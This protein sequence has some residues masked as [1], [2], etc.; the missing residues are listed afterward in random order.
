MAYIIPAWAPTDEG[1]TTEVMVNIAQLFKEHQVAYELTF[2]QSMPWLRNQLRVNHLTD[3]HWWSAFDALQRVDIQTGAP[4]G[5]YDLPLP[6]DVDRVFW[7]DQVILL[8]GEQ[9]YGS[10]RTRPGG[11]VGGTTVNTD[12]GT[13]SATYD[14]R[15]FCSIERDYD[16][17]H[18]L[19][20]TRWYTPTGELAM[21]QTPSGAVTVY[22]ADQTTASF[23]TLA[24]ALLTVLQA[25]LQP[26]TAVLAWPNSRTLSVI[27]ALAKQRPVTTVLPLKL[28]NQLDLSELLH[29]SAHVVAPTPTVTAD[30][31]ARFH[32]ELTAANTS[33]IPPYPTTF[34]LGHST[35]SPVTELLWLVNGLPEPG[36][37]TVTKELLARLLADDAITVVI[38]TATG[39]QA[40]TLRTAFQTGIVAAHSLDAKK[41]EPEFVAA[42][43]RKEDPYKDLT[44]EDRKRIT[45]D[46]RMLLTQVGRVTL[47]VQAPARDL[48][49]DMQ[50]ARVLIDLGTPP[51]L[52]A[53]TL[54]ISAGVPQI[55]LQASG[56]MH[57]RETGYLVAEPRGVDDALSYY[58]DTFTHW[59]TSLVASVA[60]GERYAAP[61]L[62]EQWKELLTHG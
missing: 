31:A 54:A 53:Q 8:R 5:V 58:L 35:E 11:Y 61:R 14:D 15:G 49:A 17:D 23:P 36:M 56:Y 18:Q 26:Q 30:A 20:A 25:H 59:N 57:D 27:L 7:H 44:D 41:G 55:N 4:L 3:A 1:L 21:T 60:E 33:M 2:L 29:A 46:I 51:Q 24:A 32:A 37:Q 9:N 62:L 10:I 12:F 50:E 40:D 22:H 13:T 16:Q 48:H 45:P 28:P 38:H 34:D 47:R 19:L 39:G 52:Y 42:L 43:L 6:A